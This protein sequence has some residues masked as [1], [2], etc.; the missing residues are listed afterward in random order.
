MRPTPEFVKV[1]LERSEN[2]RA[3]YGAAANNVLL[4]MLGDLDKDE[5]KE[6]NYFHSVDL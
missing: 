2:G 4:I 5:L 1:S 6:L 3:A